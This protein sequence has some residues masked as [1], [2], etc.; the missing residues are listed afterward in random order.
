[1]KH[2]NRQNFLW[3]Q[4]FFNPH[5]LLTTKKLTTDRKCYEI[6]VNIINQKTCNI[7]VTWLQE[8][9]NRPDG[10]QTNLSG[11]AI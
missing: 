8:K 1:M 2:S 4:H 10:K 6:N 3:K 9:T 5:C 7:I 11:L